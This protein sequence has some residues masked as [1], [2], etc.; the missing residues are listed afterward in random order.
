MRSSIFIGSVG[1]GRKNQRSR[2]ELQ[3]VMRVCILMVEVTLVTMVQ[4]LKVIMHSGK[5][6][7]ACAPV[8]RTQSNMLHKFELPISLAELQSFGGPR[9]H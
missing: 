1:G 3:V 9:V 2:V 7:D 8:H 6:E 4:M 5:L